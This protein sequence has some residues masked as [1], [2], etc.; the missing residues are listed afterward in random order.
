MADLPERAGGLRGLMS[1][2]REYAPGYWTEAVAWLLPESVREVGG[3]LL[4]LL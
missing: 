4:A 3:T 2:R 1:Y